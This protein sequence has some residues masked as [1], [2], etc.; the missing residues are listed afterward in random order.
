MPYQYK[1]GPLGDNDVNRLTNACDTFI[2]QSSI[3]KYGSYY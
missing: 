3:P 1:R 2:R